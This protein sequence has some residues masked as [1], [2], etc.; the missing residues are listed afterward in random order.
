MLRIFTQDAWR[1]MKNA[2]IPKGKQVKGLPVGQCA[3]I[4]PCTDGISFAMTN[5]E[6]L[7]VENARAKWEG[8]MFHTCVPARPF[9]DWLSVTRK[10]TEVITLELDKERE[11]LIVH[12]DNTR[13]E[14]KCLNALEF[15]MNGY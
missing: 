4:H 15:P 1:A 8:E 14:F 3:Y 7:T 5:L 13:A 6:D 12:A 10:F 2:Y 11:A 9:K